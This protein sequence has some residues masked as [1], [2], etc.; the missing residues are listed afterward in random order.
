MKKFEAL[1]TFTKSERINFSCPNFI[2][3]KPLSLQLIKMQPIRVIAFQA[4]FN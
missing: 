1:L 3:R 4:L 2:Y